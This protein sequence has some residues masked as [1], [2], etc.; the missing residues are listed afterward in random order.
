[1]IVNVSVVTLVTRTISALVASGCAPAGQIVAL[2][3]A[4]GKRVPSPAATTSDVP[5]AAGDGAV[6]I[7]E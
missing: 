2:K 1:V 3:G 7:V 6:A 4:V 5:D